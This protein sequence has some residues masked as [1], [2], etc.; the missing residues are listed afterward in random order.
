VREGGERGK[1]GGGF[2]DW[3]PF[4]RFLSRTKRM[5]ITLIH[6]KTRGGG[7]R[8]TVCGRGGTLVGAAG[9]G[10]ESQSTQGGGWFGGLCLGVGGGFKHGKKGWR[11]FI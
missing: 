3:L 9:V 11:F 7:L 5:E 6:R 1:G 4:G 10:Q 8:E 2:S